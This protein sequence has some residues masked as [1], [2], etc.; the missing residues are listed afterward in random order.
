MTSYE[1]LESRFRQIS[2]L[3]EVRNIVQWDEA[4]MMPEGASPF[5]NEALGE[6]AVVIQNLTCAEEVGAWIAEA[7]KAPPA[8]PWRQANLREIK[9]VYIENTVLPPELNQK[10]VVARMNCEQQWR[11]L[12]A[13]N[14]WAAFMP[15]LQEVLAL[16]RQM[17]G[18]LQKKTGLSTYDAAISLFSPGLNTHTV[19][20]LFDELKSFLPALV[21]K[22]VDK[23]SREKWIVP[24]GVFPMAAQK[25]LGLECMQALGFSMNIGR[26]DEAHHPFCGGN[27]R[28][29]RIT[30]RYR[31]DDFIPSLMGVLHETG[32]ALYEQ[33]LPEDWLTQPVG[34]GCGMAIHESQ[35]LLMEMQVCRSKEF[36]SFMAPLVRKHMGPHVKN[37]ESL[38]TENLLKLV[39]RVKPGFIR[40]DAD[41]VT[42]PAHVI[43]RFEI[44]RDL[45]EDRWSLSELPAVWNEKMKAYLGLSTLGDDKN[46]CMQDVH[47][48]SG[49]FGY[50][51]AYTFGAVI[52]AQLFA[53]AKEQQPS[54]PGEVAKGN[55]TPLRL[56]LNE[57]IWSRASTLRT[58]DLVEKVSGP[59][60]AAPFRK[61]LE[62]RYL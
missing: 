27:P 62:S 60:S 24:Q 50:F 22:V 44:E 38:E 4:V 9:R 10:L 34:W 26:L 17:V 51:P 23:Q 29:V 39:T 13:E 49:S 6:L 8:D 15:H 61:H 12:R 18:E 55:F 40:V 28:D 32:H 20:R 46:G 14:N 36:I 56:W 43:L 30:T 47:W 35:S 5:R 25:A 54:L 21:Q 52:A 11:K 3:S 57:N 42:Y 1:K 41:E 53:K 37:P 16:T 33:H 58:L 19:E 48:P 31:E 45:L 7:E 2:R 59:L